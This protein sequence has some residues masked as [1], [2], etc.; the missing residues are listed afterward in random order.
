MIVK[1]IVVFSHCHVSR[2]MTR[3]LV[4]VNLLSAFFNNTPLVN[5]IKPALYVPRLKQSPTGRP[6]DADCEGLGA[7][8][9]F[10]EAE[11]PCFPLIY[12]FSLST[13]FL[14]SSICIQH[15]QRF[16]KQSDTLDSDRSSSYLSHSLQSR[17]A[18]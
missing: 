4:I 11:A 5:I 15:F 6:H 13:S 9:Q 16:L 8:S 3:F 2:G 7:I 14:F 17:V 12:S 10:S 18:S 1:D